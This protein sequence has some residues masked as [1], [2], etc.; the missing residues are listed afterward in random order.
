MH[1]PHLLH[2]ALQ[3]R[4]KLGYAL[5]VLACNC[6]N[7]RIELL[8]VC[9]LFL[10]KLLIQREKLDLLLQRCLVL[11]GERMQQLV[12]LGALQHN[13]LVKFVESG[14]RFAGEFLDVHF[15][16]FLKV[17]ALVLHILQRC[18]KLGVL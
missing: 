16:L 6:V 15:E 1:P 7:P 8:L 10:S 14:F 17:A 12:G 9:L 5:F 11:A 4:L 13:L 2:V 3:S 18:S